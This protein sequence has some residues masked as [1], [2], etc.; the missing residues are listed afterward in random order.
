M[1]ETHKDD[2]VTWFWKL[3]DYIDTINRWGLEGSN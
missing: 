1:G 3:N 2:I